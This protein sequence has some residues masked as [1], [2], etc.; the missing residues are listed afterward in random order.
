MPPRKRKRNIEITEKL[1]L[2]QIVILSELPALSARNSA[3]KWLS[4]QCEEVRLSVIVRQSALISTRRSPGAAP[5]PEFIY[6]MLIMAITIEQRNEA[7]LRLKRKLTALE[8]DEISR[9]RIKGFAA[10]KRMRSA[11]KF[12]RIKHSYYALIA[13]LREEENFS[14]ADVAHYLQI[15]HQYIASRA[16]IQQSYAKI[17]QGLADVSNVE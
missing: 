8:A 5:S 17:K 14:W 13:K 10:N 11:E 12:A 9:K 6:S 15:Y 1:D 2:T 7:A 16:Y 3:L 4:E